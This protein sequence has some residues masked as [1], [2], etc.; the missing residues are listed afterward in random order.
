MPYNRTASA[1]RDG[2]GAKTD[3]QSTN[4][5]LRRVAQAGICYLL[6]QEDVKTDGQ[7][8][9]LFF[10]GVYYLIVQAITLLAPR[11]HE[12]IAP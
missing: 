12:S 1:A 6:V 5:F 2:E 10:A 3:G 8:D 11:S 4:L 9:A 7:L